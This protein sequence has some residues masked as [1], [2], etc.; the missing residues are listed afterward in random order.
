MRHCVDLK[1]P[2]KLGERVFT[3]R[4]PAR[5]R[6]DQAG[7]LSKIARLLQDFQRPA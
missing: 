7:D 2:E 6:E 1:L 4:T 3:Y 5:R